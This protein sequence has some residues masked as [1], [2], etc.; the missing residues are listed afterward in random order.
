MSLYAVLFSL[1][2]PQKIIP[3]KKSIFLRYEHSGTNAE[4]NNE[5][6]GMFLTTTPRY[7]SE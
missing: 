3:E 6:K 2:I 5:S 1:L 4:M 7:L